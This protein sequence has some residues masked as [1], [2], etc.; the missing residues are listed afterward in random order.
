VQTST[1]VFL[2]K[3][4]EI[5]NVGHGELLGLPAKGGP[6]GFGFPRSFPVISV[7]SDFI[8]YTLLETPP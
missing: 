1:D 6:F 8:N 4:I 2:G 5:A 7:D 3:R